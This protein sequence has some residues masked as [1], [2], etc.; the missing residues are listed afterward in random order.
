MML[1]WLEVAL[2]AIRLTREEDCFCGAENEAL[3]C[4][5]RA[6]TFV[7]ENFDVRR[8]VAEANVRAISEG[9]DHV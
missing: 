2:R 7:A 9:A 4:A 5:E 3:N 1:F 8:K 6:L